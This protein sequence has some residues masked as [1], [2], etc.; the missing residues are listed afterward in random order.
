MP[1][2]TRAECVVFDSRPLT[3]PE[4]II[5]VVVLVLSGLLA[6]VGMPTLSVLMLL[7]GSTDTAFRLIR[8]VRLV[9]QSAVAEV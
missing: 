2:V 9:K 5:I 8:R 6:L 3:T 1:D 7:T 4:A